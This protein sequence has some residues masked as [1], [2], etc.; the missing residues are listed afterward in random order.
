MQKKV[1]NKI[2]PEINRVENE[3]HYRKLMLAFKKSKRLKY[4]STMNWLVSDCLPGELFQ[5]F[6]VTIMLIPEKLFHWKAWKEHFPTHFTR[7]VSPQE[8][9]QAKTL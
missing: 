2:R 7:P 1:N 9:N 8:Q 4:L 5:T 3:K 6:K